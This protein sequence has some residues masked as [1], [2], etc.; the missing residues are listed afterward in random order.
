MEINLCYDPREVLLA[1]RAALKAKT[2]PYVMDARDL[3]LVN[4]GKV[5]H[6]HETEPDLSILK[7]DVKLTAYV[8]DRAAFFGMLAWQIIA[9][10]KLED[11]VNNEVDARFKKGHTN[12]ND[13][14]KWTAITDKIALP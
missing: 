14:L 9:I 10:D 12:K 11:A 8:K 4:M 6:A 3:Q 13:L 1:C 5:E 7:L 2:M